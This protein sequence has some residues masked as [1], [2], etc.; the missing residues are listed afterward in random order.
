MV[1]M[2]YAYKQYGII[3]YLTHVTWCVTLLQNLPVNTGLK[4]LQYVKITSTHNTNV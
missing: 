4:G 3:H 1:E 2:M